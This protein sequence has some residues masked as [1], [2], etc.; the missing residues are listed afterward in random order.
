MIS[1]VAQPHRRLFVAERRAQHPDQVVGH[2]QVVDLGAVGG[3]G[4]QGAPGRE[5]VVIVVGLDREDPLGFPKV[6]A[7]DRHAASLLGTA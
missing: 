6:R 2:G 7:G 5:V 1:L 3:E 4:C